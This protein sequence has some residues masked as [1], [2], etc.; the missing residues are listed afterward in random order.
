MQREKT[1][2]KVYEVSVGFR[3]FGKLV[4]IYKTKQLA[5]K[6]MNKSIF[7]YMKQDILIYE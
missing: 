1:I 6:Y 7:R 2:Y 4:K 5:E 3:R